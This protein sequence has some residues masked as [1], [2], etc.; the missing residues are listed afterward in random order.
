MTGYIRAALSP[1]LVI[2]YVFG[3]R[4]VEFPAGKPRL[5]FSFLYIF[6]SWSV[7][8]ILLIYTAIHYVNDHPFT[9]HIAFHLN[10]FIAFLSVVLGIYYDKKYRNCLRKLAIIDDTLE[11]LGTATDYQKVYMTVL[12][13]I[14]GWIA[15][16]ISVTYVKSFWLR[17]R[18]DALKAM[19]V[20]FLLEYVSY[21]NLIGDLII[22]STLRYIE[23]KFDQVNE[24]LRKSEEVDEYETK[25]TWEHFM[26]HSRPVGYPKSSRSKY[27][28]WIVIHLH[29]ELRKICREVNSIF[30]LQMT[31]K[32]GCYFAFIS[33]NISEIF[34]AIFNDTY[35]SDTY[36]NKNND[37]YINKNKLFFLLIAI[38]LA[39][40]LFRL[41]LINYMCERV[42]VKVSFT[43]SYLTYFVFAFTRVRDCLTIKLYYIYIPLYI[44]IRCAETRSCLAHFNYR[45][46]QREM[47]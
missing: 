23:L 47:L 17:D 6:L 13:V 29:L 31:L 41:F 40:Y 28:T 36:L 18:C 3:T 24:Y 46:M 16:A 2:S 4:I 45:Q 8:H 7:Y 27:T 21:I 12:S 25:R 44:Q 22:A 15:F 35:I 32:M 34:K 30:E 38:S 20:S 19:Y 1:L 5:W 43:H 42:S 26:L 14:F 11:K 33:R 37:S 10:I 39:I 9:Y